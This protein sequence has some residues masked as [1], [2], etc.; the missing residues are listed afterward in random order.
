MQVYTNVIYVAVITFPFLAALVTIPFMIHQYR[1]L[2]SI[3]WW[4]TFL[5]YLFVFYL[6]CAYFMVLLPMPEDRAAVVPYAQTPQ[7]I[8]FHFVL[9]FIAES[10]IRLTSPSSWLKELT[11]P[12]VYQAIFN[13]ALLIP[14]GM[15]LRYFF[16]RSWWQTLII[17]FSVTLSFE[18]LQLTGIFGIYMHP[19]RLFDVDDLMLNTLGAMT[20]FRIM[21]PAMKILPDLHA[22]EEKAVE[23]GLRPGLL[24]RGLSLWLDLV[25][26]GF[27]NG[28]LS[29]PLVLSGVGVEDFS[30]TIAQVTMFPL[31]DIIG[32]ILIFIV[33]PSLTGGQTLGQKICR[34][35]LVRSE[36]EKPS[37]YQYLARYGLL[38]LMLYGPIWIYRWTISLSSSLSSTSE[39]YPLAG[40]VVMYQPFI[41]VAGLLLF[42]IWGLSLFIRNHTAKRQRRLFVMLNEKL[43]GTRIVA[44]PRAT[45][46]AK[47][48]AVVADNH[49]KTS[50]EEDFSG[51]GS[52]GS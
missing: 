42:F 5:F 22:L 10:E 46:A 49:K 47:S 20:G 37:W 51:N 32:Y 40:L 39:L 41:E 35:A 52:P 30:L 38:Y 26:A 9:D 45:V 1:K 15:F 31:V 34:L 24:R 25:F 7:L 8:P 21:G 12:A 3:P 18:I 27:V 29:L 50:V 14:L 17:G 28:L 6:L 44:K 16:Q 36:A 11:H 4:K 19:Y 43:S 2:G 48:K 33:V 23:K 13:I